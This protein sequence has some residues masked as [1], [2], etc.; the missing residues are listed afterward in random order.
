MPLT[1]KETSQRERDK[2]AANGV[3]EI[4]NVF[5]P[6]SS[7]KAEKAKIQA[8]ADSIHKEVSDES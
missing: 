6:V 4:R 8:Y 7:G 3:K 5:V 1:T 2:R